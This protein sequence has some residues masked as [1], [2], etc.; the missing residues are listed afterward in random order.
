[1]DAPSRRQFLTT[2]ASACPWHAFAQ[3]ALADYT[4]DAVL[5]LGDGRKLGYRIF[6]NPGDNVVL[7]FHGSPGSRFEAEFVWRVV[8]Q[9]NI[10]LISVDRPGM[11][12]S[13]FSTRCSVISWPG[14]I[15][16]LLSHL[17]ATGFSVETVKVLATSGGTS[18]SLAC[19]QQLAPTVAS[20]AVISPRTPLAPG[21]PLSELDRKLLQ[22][23]KAPRLARLLLR[24]Q[25]DLLK[26]GSDRAGKSQFRVFAPVDQKFAEE[27]ESLFRK[28]ILEAARCGVKGILY[29]FAEIMWPWNVCLKQIQVPIS[30][31]HGDCDYSAPR[32]TLGFLQQN[33]PTAEA[34][35]L[36]GE[37]HFTS[38]PAAAP[39]AIDWLLNT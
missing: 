25:I 7:Y 36:N 10:C 33:L 3:P 30:F 5:S 38:L 11:G 29:E 12:L 20:V 27:H 22:A 39:S 17:K 1:M 35:S 26:R 19:A 31:W 37:G 21:V 6:G 13:T 32:Q 23:N 28:I 34:F 8:A 14:D 18:F 16:A 24:R 2:I 4:R 9:K 15:L